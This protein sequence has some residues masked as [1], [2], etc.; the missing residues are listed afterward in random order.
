MSDNESN[1][2]IEVQSIKSEEN[3]GEV[4]NTNNDNFEKIIEVNEAEEEEDSRV[5]EDDVNEAIELQNQSKAVVFKD[6]TE[7]QKKLMSTEPS[8]VIEKLDDE[9]SEMSENDQE[10]EVNEEDEEIEIDILEDENSDVIYE[11]SVTIEEKM[12]KSEREKIYV[13][14]TIMLQEIQNQ[15]LNALPVT[16]QS[17]LYVQKRIEREAMKIMQTRKMGIDRFEMIEKGI[18]YNYDVP[19][20]IPIVLD[21]HKVYIILQEEVIEKNEEPNINKMMMNVNNENSGFTESKE[22]PQGIQQE[23]QKDQMKKIKEL[24][25]ATYQK[26]HRFDHILN[27]IQNIIKPYV[28]EKTLSGGDLTSEPKEVG[29]YHSNKKNTL[30]LRYYDIDSIYWNSHQILDQISTFSHVEDEH[31]HITSLQEETLIPSEG[32]NI[33]GFMVLPKAGKDSTPLSSIFTPSNYQSNYLYKFYQKIGSIER[34]TISQDQKSILL[35]ITNHQLSSEQHYVIIEDCDYSPNINGIHR[36]VQVIDGNTISIKNKRKIPMLREGSMGTLYSLNR[37]QYDLYQLEMNAENVI[38]QFVSSNYIDG[39]ES[40]EHLKVYLFEKKKIFESNY[41]RILQ[42]I[43]PSLTDIIESEKEEF[44]KCDTLEEMEEILKPYHIKLSQLHSSQMEILE[45]ILKKNLEKFEKEAIAE[46]DSEIPKFIFH[47]SNKLIMQNPNLFLADVYIQSPFIQRY[48]SKYPHLHLSEDS[49]IGRLSWILSQYDH[50]LLY[51]NYVLYE[52]IEEFEKNHSKGDIISVI[53]STQNSIDELDKTLRKEIDLSKKDKKTCKLYH[54]EALPIS[55]DMKVAGLDEKTMIAKEGDKIAYYL[56]NGSVF[57]HEDKLQIVD[58]GKAQPLM[59]T[60]DGVMALVG[61]HVYIWNGKDQWEKSEILPKYHQIRFLCDF[62]DMDIQQIDL[63]T[64]DCVYREKTGCNSRII[65][66]LKDKIQFLEDTKVDFEE[67]KEYVNEQTYKKTIE[68]NIQHIIFK[69]FSKDITSVQNELK[70]NRKVEEKREEKEKNEKKKEEEK[71]ELESEEEM[72]N[73]HPEL[74]SLIYQIN[75]MKND[76]LK[77]E[78]I[79]QLI[80]K[81]GL[82]IG[83]TIY[84]KKYKCKMN[85][86]CGH[87]IFDIRMSRTTNVERRT[88]LLTQ[89]LTKFGDSGEAEHEKIKCTEC[90]TELGLVDYDIVEGYSSSG[91]FIVNRG[92]LEEETEDKFSEIERIALSIAHDCGSEQFQKLLA[93]E[94]YFVGDDPNILRF[95]E[96]VIEGLCEKTGVSITTQELINIIKDSMI[97]AKT[98]LSPPQFIEAK[99]RLLMDEDGLPE[100]T[101]KELEIKGYFKQLYDRYYRIKW[102]SIVASRFLVSVQTALPTFIRSPL[103]AVGNF[104]SFDGK[105][106]IQYLGEIFGILNFVSFG[107]KESSSDERTT[108][109]TEIDKSYKEFIQ[110]PH[111]RELYRKK[112][113]Y[114]KELKDKRSLILD[115][116]EPI[117]IRM[118]TYK[119]VEPLPEDFEEKLLKAKNK[120]EFSKMMQHLIQRIYFLGQEMKRIIRET[121]DKDPLIDQTSPFVEKYCCLETLDDYV[122]YYTY[123]QIKYPN[124]EKESIYQYIDESKK[125]YNI[126]NHI[127]LNKGSISF[128]TLRGEQ[129]THF[130]MNPIIVLN[131]ETVSQSIIQETFYYYVNSGKYVGTL[132]NYIGTGMDAK[133]VK[134]GLTRKQIEEKEYTKQEF[135]QLLSEIVK[136]N[137]KIPV[138]KNKEKEEEDKIRL[139]EWKKSAQ[140]KLRSDISVLVQNIAS[141]LNKSMDTGFIQKYNRLIEN[142]GVFTKDYVDRILPDLEYEEKVDSESKRYEIKSHQLQDEYRLLYIKRVFNDYFRKYL[143]LIRHNY[144]QKELEELTF[145]T[146]DVSEEMVNEIAFEQMRFRP[147]FEP[148]IQP[149][150]KDLSFQS[151]YQSIE[152]IH[153]SN[154][155]YNFTNKLYEGEIIHHSSF[156]INDASLVVLHLLVKELNQL[157]MCVREDKMMKEEMMEKMRDMEQEEMERKIMDIG[158]KKC[159]AICEFMLTVFSLVERDEELLSLCFQKLYVY[160]N[161]LVRQVQL[162]AKKNLEEELEKTD[163]FFMKVYNIQQMKTQTGARIGEVEEELENEQNEFDKEMDKNDKE[164]A[165]QDRL[166]KLSNEKGRPLTEDEKA[167]LTQMVMTE[168]ENEEML[169]EEEN[170]LMNVIDEDTAEDTYEI[171]GDGDYGDV[172]QENDG[173]L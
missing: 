15:L 44:E 154:T 79:N 172:V 13:D 98:I 56:P 40:N 82:L 163:N 151:S 73:E 48:Y 49:L 34:A 57:Y 114:V 122:D 158:S 108:F 54:Y 128:F 18:D 132:R 131:P 19:W 144:N 10:V 138:K 47:E 94:G 124:H 27:D 147:Y 165:I 69:Y 89:M 160:K 5:D 64:L 129:L 51:I 141:V 52:N 125:L 110:L 23:N 149:Y 139:Q 62:Q 146:K 106:G 116:D 84:S 134:S 115:G 31:G 170:E 77:K 162:K 33:V 72:K 86:I 16:K 53:E 39:E 37:L 11:K 140:E 26:S 136:K 74:T 155:I 55:E 102:R 65:G 20:I 80:E 145:V 29:Y 105:H 135:Q 17:L 71:E 3:E 168:M 14:E 46:D 93:K 90:G 75:Q 42:K 70:I 164:E 83:K 4:L 41:H 120:S 68:Q 87:K 67:L 111:I 85:G 38:P 12:A 92:L 60:V 137:T 117:Q 150:F 126:F 36:S 167:E 30:A 142:M 78:L 104:I 101:I 153:G 7:R 143:S 156:D 169:D 157:I 1:E 61:D 99:K 2:N 6:L 121:I 127:Y 8:V 21:K 161:V 88:L 43:A 35:T 112:A 107:G 25:S 24:E 81:D 119:R 58:K 148:N 59:G 45:E 113:Q 152:S 103:K 97:K 91:A 32:M 118:P 100:R 76:D 173:D 109:E 96:F 123:I 9:A 63:D 50:G 171:L 159:K 133:D 166:Q 130:I 22:D 66:R 28:V 95:C